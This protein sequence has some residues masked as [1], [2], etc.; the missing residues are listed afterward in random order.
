M[1]KDELAALGRAATQGNWNVGNGDI[2][3]DGDEASDYDDKVICGIGMAGLRSH[4]Y[5]VIKAHKPQGKA[6]AALIVA[7]VNLYRTGKLVL[8]D[9][10][11]VEHLREVFNAGRESVMDAQRGY[12]TC[13]ED[14]IIRHALSAL[15]G[16]R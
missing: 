1:D 9:D 4:E 5:A 12:P 16:E 13:D 8:I 3:A 10:G 2:Y 11:A 15:K 14:A 7:L 6:N